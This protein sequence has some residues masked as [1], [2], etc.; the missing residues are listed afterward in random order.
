MATIGFIFRGWVYRCLVTYEAIGQRRN[1]VAS[2][3]SLINHINATERNDVIDIKKIINTSLSLTSRQLKFTTG[4][5][6]ED[7]N[8]LIYSKNANCVGYAAFFSATCNQLF[9]KNS[10]VDEWSAQPQIGQLYCLGINVHPYFKSAF[11]KDH[12]FV[13]V[14]NKKTGQTLAVDPSLNDYTGI[15]YVT[16]SKKRLQ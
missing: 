13:I 4:N 15:E 16:L 14:K 3:S 7:P 6:D 11:F 8:K 12:D 2:D 5:N 1:Y 9:E 10:L